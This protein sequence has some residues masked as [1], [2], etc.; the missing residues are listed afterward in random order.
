M[1]RLVTCPSDATLVEIEFDES[2]IDGTILG[3][4]G[5]TRFKPAS[6]LDCDTECIHRLNEKLDTL[7]QVEPPAEDD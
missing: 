6:E 5:C 3:V 4:R 2:P 7:V 1:K